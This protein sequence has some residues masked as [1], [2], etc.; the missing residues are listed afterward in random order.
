MWHPSSACPGGVM[1]MLSDSRAGYPGSI[2][3]DLHTTACLKFSFCDIWNIFCSWNGYF[4]D[5]NI[6]WFTALYLSQ[7]SLIIIW[8]LKIHVSMHKPFLSYYITVERV[9]FARIYFSRFSR[10]ELH[11]RKTHDREISSVAFLQLYGIISKCF[12]CFFGYF[13][14]SV[15]TAFC[16]FAKNRCSRKCWLAIREQ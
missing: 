4:D 7:Q 16:P 15:F 9:F 11:S 8:F 2:P 14:S 3:T 10:F 13:L 1:A 12:G 5:E 6:A